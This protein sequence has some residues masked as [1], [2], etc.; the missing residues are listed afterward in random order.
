MRLFYSTLEKKIQHAK[1]TYFKSSPTIDIV[2]LKKKEKKEQSCQ[3]LALKRDLFHNC[4]SWSH[5]DIKKEAV[6]IWKPFWIK[7]RVMHSEYIFL[8]LVMVCYTDVCF[9]GSIVYRSLVCHCRQRTTIN[10][11]VY[12]I[13][14]TLSKVIH[15]L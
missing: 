7:I 14:G 9:L 13:A 10:M 6:N 2:I 4:M 5:W 12:F 11:K 8:W 3:N 1:H 15:L